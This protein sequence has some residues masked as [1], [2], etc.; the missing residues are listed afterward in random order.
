MANPEKIKVHY[1]IMKEM[2][3]EARAAAS[4]APQQRTAPPEPVQKKAI[5]APAPAA[6]A[7]SGAMP[8]QQ[9]S[10]AAEEQINSL[11]LQIEE[12]DYE[13]SESLTEYCSPH[14]SLSCSSHSHRHAVIVLEKAKEIRIHG[15]CG[16]PSNDGWKQWPW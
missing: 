16:Y 12:R 1:Q 7:S 13:I 5:E 15:I 9:L 2:I 6:A 3:L 4:A 11:M 8:P 14:H 10:A